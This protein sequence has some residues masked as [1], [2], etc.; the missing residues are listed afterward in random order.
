MSLTRPLNVLP[1]FMAQILQARVALERLSAFFN[2]EEVDSFVSSLKQP[3]PTTPSDSISI[4]SPTLGITGGARFMWNSV[5]RANPNPKVTVATPADNVSES[6]QS[7]VD[8]S[9]FELKYIQTFFHLR[10][11]TLVDRS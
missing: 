4:E 1:N 2:E 6:S 7:P 8:E 11:L 9:R 3:P 10:Q 5:E